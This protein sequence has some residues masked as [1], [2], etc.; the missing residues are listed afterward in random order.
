MVGQAARVLARAFET[1]PLQVAAF[2]PAVRTL[3]ETFFRIALAALKGPKHVVTD[4]G[5]VIGLVHWVEAPAC[6]LSG[7]EKLRLAPAMLRGFG[8]RAALRV[9]SWRGAWAKHDPQHEPHLHLGPIGVDPD[10][11]GRGIGR[12]LMERYCTETDSRGL[13]GYLETDRPENVAIYRRFGFET[14]REAPVIGVPSYF[15]ARPARSAPPT[16]AP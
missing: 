9:G 12:I 1:N 15:M 3:N 2:G 10:A 14:R 7:A 16:V 6:Q 5:R 11:Q 8:L 4:E 13:A